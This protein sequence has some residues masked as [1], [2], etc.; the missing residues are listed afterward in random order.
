MSNTEAVVPTEVG[1]TSIRK[2]SNSSTEPK[3]VITAIHFEI[4]L[5][6]EQKAFKLE[7]QSALLIMMT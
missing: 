1:D 6:A 4:L 7:E 2:H 3:A 5:L